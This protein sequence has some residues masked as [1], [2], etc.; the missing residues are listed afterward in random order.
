MRSK[1]YNPERRDDSMSHRSKPGLLFLH[2][3]PLDGSMWAG[4]MDIAGI[5]TCAPTLYGL[6]DTVESWAIEALKQTTSERL[7]VVGCSVG[8]SCALEVAAAAP[9]RVAALVL[10]GTK[11][12]HD[13][14]PELH[15]QALELLETE[16]AAGA[17]TRYWAP[18]F[19]RSAHPEIVAAARRAALRQHAGG[20]A[21]GI[22]AF[23][24]RQSRDRLVAACQIP[25]TVIT[26]EEDLAPGLKTSTEIVA[27]A[28]HGSL[29]VIPDCGHYV[30]LEKP[31]A[32]RSILND[33]IQAQV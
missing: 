3:L 14:D 24:R 26:G 20:L 7:I 17:W 29:H 18:L 21:C 19:S 8:G 1:T 30:P 16:G 22:T 27:S 11:A 31:E 28:R 13:P 10:I 5:S 2:A 4:H 15:A 33:V 12:R 23:H 32:L 25:I 6:G 9:Q